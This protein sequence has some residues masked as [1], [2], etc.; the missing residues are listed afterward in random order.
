MP[1]SNLFSQIAELFHTGKSVLSREFQAAGLPY[2]ATYLKVTRLIERVQPCTAQTLVQLLQRDK[3]QITRLLNDMEK[4]GLIAREPN[5]HDRRSQLLVL[6]AKGREDF[7][8]MRA[9]EARMVKQMTK[10]MNR[11]ERDALLSAM[12]R[13]R[14]N[15]Q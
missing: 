15:L 14:D 13:I 6:S 4:Q 12:A 7:E 5:P 3:A 2:P 8:T 10:G 1:Q 9:I 11:E